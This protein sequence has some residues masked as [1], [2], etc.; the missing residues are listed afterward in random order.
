MGFHNSIK[1]G[2][3]RYFADVKLKPCSCG[4]TELVI[5]Q[6][7]DEFQRVY[8]Q[9]RECKKRGLKQINKKL[10]SIFWNKAKAQFNQSLNPTPRSDR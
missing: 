3:P 1:A 10:A 8:V 4:S 2:R 5:E 9:C 6:S 7:Y